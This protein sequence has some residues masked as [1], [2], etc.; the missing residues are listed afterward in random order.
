MEDEN[1]SML[2]ARRTRGDNTLYARATPERVEL[3][4][5]YTVEQEISQSPWVHRVGDGTGRVDISVPYDGHRFF[6]REAVADTE[7]ALGHRGTPGDHR[8]TIGHL[9]LADH[10]KTSGLSGLMRLHNQSGVIPLTIPVAAENGML[11]LTGDR[12]TCVIAHDYQPEYPHVIPIRLDVTLYDL[13]SLADQL[14]SVDGP[15]GTKSLVA[16]GR[17]NPSMYIEKLR[18]KA[19]FSSGLLLA[20][21]VQIAVPVKANYPR[22]SPVVTDISVAWPTLTS[23]RS[24][25]LVIGGQG[26]GA[27]RYNPVHGRLE[28]EDVPTTAL[29]GGPES[30]VETRFYQSALSILEIGHPGELFREEQL[31]VV[32][33]VEIPN[34]LLSGIEARLFDATG[35][36]T[37]D[38]P[39]LTTKL[40][41]RTLVRP[42]DIFAGRTFSPYQQFVFDDI[43]PEE[44]RVT[45]IANVLHGAG[46][47]VEELRPRDHR[48]ELAPT[49][50][51]V[52]R[53][54][55]GPDDLELLIAVEGKRFVLG[56]EELIGTNIKHVADRNS[57]QLKISVLGT[58][59]REHKELTRVM[60]ALQ[61]ELRDRY[62]PHQ[63]S[64]VSG[65]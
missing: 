44:I 20:F 21:M 4:E 38:Q 3:T 28:W 40:S 48:D 53:R 57:G 61:K 19:S 25:K 37:G 11:D 10:A 56:R 16:R 58:L 47:K 51:L 35:R 22:L 2:G 13:D 27:V 46:F 54:S 45:D 7:K 52:A 17:E 33:Q 18:Q 5:T 30:A 64:R 42:T 6:T 60:N 12:Q 15:F 29:P 50:L 14:D 34:Y 41:L 39:Q 31:Q 59:R 8:A 32:V 65:S 9:L 23:L 55:E 43:V 36:P 1:L 24:T 62:R 26:R 49:W 63:T